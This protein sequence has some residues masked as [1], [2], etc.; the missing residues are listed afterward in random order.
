MISPV[1]SELP[2]LTRTNS[3]GPIFPS[4]AAHAIW[5]SRTTFSTLVASFIEGMTIVN[6]SLSGTSEFDH[7][8]GRHASPCQVAY[9]MHGK[10]G[11]FNLVPF[12]G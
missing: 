12:H 7:S 2:S 10:H 8:C 1:L 11:L 3:T 4:S 5:T 6:G 9:L